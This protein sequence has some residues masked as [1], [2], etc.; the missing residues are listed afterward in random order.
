[1]IFLIFLLTLGSSRLSWSQTNTSSISGTVTDSTGA[2][3]PNASVNLSN[4]A[5]GSAQAVQ[6]SSKGEF[7]FEQLA[8][9]TY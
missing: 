2:L 5:S 3:L 4:A 9:G 6:S 7:A 8:P 1:M